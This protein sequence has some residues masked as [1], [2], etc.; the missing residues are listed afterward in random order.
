MRTNLLTIK[1]QL[2]YIP[3]F[4]TF[5]VLAKGDINDGVPFVDDSAIDWYLA[6]WLCKSSIFLSYDI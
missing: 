6:I 5:L 4:S 2:I 3:E 1:F